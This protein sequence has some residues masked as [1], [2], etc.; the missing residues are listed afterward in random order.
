MLHS[1]RRKIK[2]DGVQAGIEGAEKQDFDPPVGTFPL[3]I[4]H[5]MGD[6]V[7]CKTDDEDS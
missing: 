7:G 3:N 4:T 2:D 5:H 1:G 6:V